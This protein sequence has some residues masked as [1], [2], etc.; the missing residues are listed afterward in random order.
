[1]A[2]VTFK[3]N[4]RDK[5]GKVVSGK[6]EGENREAVATKLR[7]M[8]YIV[9]DLDEDRLARLNK[10]QFGTTVKTKDVTIFSR[11]FATMI[12][13]GLSLTK[14]LSILGAQSES[15]ELREVIAQLGRDV[16]AGQSLS[17]AMVK[18]P[19]IFPPIF[20]NM[21]RAGETGGVLDEVLLRVADLF[22]ADASLKGRIKSAMTYPIAMLALVLIILVAM[23]IFVVPTFEKMFS[24]M[25]GTLPL[26]TQ[27]LVNIS[28]GATS[29]PG[30]VVVAV[31]IIIVVAFKMWVATDSGRFIWDG[32]L[33][34]MPIV[35]PLQRKTAIARFTR[36]FSTLVA[37]G[38]PILS[39]M[40]I[41]ADT[42]G[43]EVVA[44]AL[45]NARGAIKEGE[46]I[47]KP[48]SESPVFP[49]MVVQM[50]A[51]G[52]E[53]GALDQ[54]LSKIADFYDE[55]VSQAVDALTSVIEPVMMAT[56]GVIVGGMVIALYMPM[57][58]SITLIK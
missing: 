41:V 34:R 35:G 6:L 10:I 23:M 26:P 1:M 7:Q 54:M 51:V 58:Q 18:H 44:R 22:E 37:A 30:L 39:A 5:T 50:V 45:K 15:R 38:V 14:C 55:E 52:E 13:A 43:N 49:S 40:D 25:G 47:A 12:N 4:V 46:T 31:I 33:L 2:T 57:F 16:E 32:I 19:K 42:A 29:W 36:T 28:N 11:Q 9:L 27:I 24:D 53:T 3:Y 17:E 8:G 21:V 56:L 48:L 20:Y